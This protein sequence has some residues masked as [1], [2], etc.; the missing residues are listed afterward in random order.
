MMAT[1]KPSK[2]RWMGKQRE[3]APG[4]VVLGIKELA[5]KWGCSRSVIQKHLHYLH[6]TGRIVF[7]SCSRGSLITICNWAEYQ[8]NENT[9]ESPSTHGV[10]APCSPRVHGEA[11]SEEGKKERREEESTLVQE[12]SEC[13]KAW[14][15]TLARFEI[16]RQPYLDR[17]HI[18]RLIQRHGFDKTCLALL[19]AG[20]EEKTKDYDP[21]KHVSIYRLVKNPALFD[22]FVSLGAKAA[23]EE[24][25]RPQTRKWGA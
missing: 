1:W 17:E 6:D 22:K 4:S 2:I 3:L 16:P 10:F 14:G 25:T 19:G 18:A 5:D 12:I 20:F 13:E 24:N 11:L 23:Q 21:A 7:E 8:S 15:K 9:P